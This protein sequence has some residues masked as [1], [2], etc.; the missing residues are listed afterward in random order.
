MGKW[1]ETIGVGFGTAKRK[2]TTE[3]R[4]VI[5]EFTGKI[6]GYHVEHWDDHV[7]AVVK[8]DHITVTR[9]SLLGGDA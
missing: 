1:Q 4:P 9:E 8:P 6:G 7:D 2:G 5:N 3:K